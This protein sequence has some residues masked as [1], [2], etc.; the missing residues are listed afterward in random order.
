MGNTRQHAY[1]LSP[2]HEKIIERHARNLERIAGFQI[3]RSNALRAIIE[4]FG[5]IERIREQRICA[6]REMLAKLEPGPERDQAQRALDDWATM[7]HDRM[8]DLALV[9]AIGLSATHGLGR[10][11]VRRGLDKLREEEIRSEIA[12]VRRA[13]NRS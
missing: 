8:A 13:R 4:S 9:Q 10:E 7:S 6:Y 1:R 5:R 12:A 2:E 3:T 11:S